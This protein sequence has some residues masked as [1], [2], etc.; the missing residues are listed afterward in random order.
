MQYV[1]KPD[2]LAVLV[3]QAD[4]IVNSTPLTDE[5]VGMFN[6]AIF[7]HMRPGA[8]FS[9]SAEGAAVVTADL[10]AALRGGKLAVQV[11]M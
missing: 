1:G 3:G 8:S 4:F 2:E 7:A 5:T 6:A 11:S 9:M 10:V